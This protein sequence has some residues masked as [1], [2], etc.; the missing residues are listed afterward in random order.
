MESENEPKRV[1]Y[2]K[3]CKIYPAR[4]GH[5]VRQYYVIQDNT[6]AKS[7]AIGKVENES[8]IPDAH[9]Q[10]GKYII[11]NGRLVRVE[12]SSNKK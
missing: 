7:K 6:D 5:R 10:P 3:G 4:D 11:N 12:S 9:Q 1:K 8:V 2:T